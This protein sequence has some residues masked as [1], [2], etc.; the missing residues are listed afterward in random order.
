MD[1]LNF[2]IKIIGLAIISICFYIGYLLRKIN[3]DK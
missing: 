1:G 3:N 2:W